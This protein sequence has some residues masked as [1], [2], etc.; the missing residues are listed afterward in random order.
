VPFGALGISQPVREG[1]SA[2]KLGLN[3]NY[4]C[5]LSIKLISPN[6]PAFLTRDIAVR[7]PS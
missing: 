4:C 1:P 5:H 2:F 7:R 6:T 3:C